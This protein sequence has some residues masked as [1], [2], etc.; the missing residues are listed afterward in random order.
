MLDFMW[1]VGV[2]FV[3]EPFPAGLRASAVSAICL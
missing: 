1:I 3:Y 2:R